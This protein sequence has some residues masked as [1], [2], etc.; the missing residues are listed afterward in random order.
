MEIIVILV[1]VIVLCLVL[2]ISLQF[3]VLGL[4]ALIGVVSGLFALA[5][6]GCAVCLLGARKKEASFLRIDRVKGGKFQAAYYLVDGQE[7]P[8]IFPKEV[9]L[10][11]RLYQTNK[12]YHVLLHEKMGKVFDR[13]AIVTCVLGLVAGTV[14]SV[15]ILI[16]FLS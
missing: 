7:Y 13:F 6:W 15:G 12:T 5:F 14:L 8:C 11:N 10:E 2:D 3:I 16:Y 1:I 4:I 9:V